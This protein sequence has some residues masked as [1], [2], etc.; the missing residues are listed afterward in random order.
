[1]SWPDMLAKANP[2][3]FHNI[4]VNRVLQNPIHTSIHRRSNTG[5]RI[6]TLGHASCVL[7]TW[8]HAFPPHQKRL[9]PLETLFFWYPERPQNHPL[10]PPLPPTLSTRGPFST[11]S[12]YSKTRLS[13][14]LPQDILTNRNISTGSFR[15]QFR[16]IPYS[17]TPPMGSLVRRDPRQRHTA[18]RELLVCDSSSQQKAG[19]LRKTLE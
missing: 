6:L 19:A 10:L 15:P 7:S 2:P 5:N 14:Q 8:M 16:L 13:P 1:M 18:I 11:V 4:G 17:A 9:P 3:M 12:V